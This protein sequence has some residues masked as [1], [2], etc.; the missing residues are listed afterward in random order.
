MKGQKGIL[1]LTCAIE[2]YLTARARAAMRWWRRLTPF[3]QQLN[4]L[5]GVKAPVVWDS[6]GRD[7]A[8]AE[9]KFTE[10]VTGIA[11]GGELVEC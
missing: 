9:I 10:A 11:T 4:A 8:R 1:G 6:A 7:I 5:T 2:H 3:I